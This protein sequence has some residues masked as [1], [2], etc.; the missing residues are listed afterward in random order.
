MDGRKPEYISGLSFFALLCASFVILCDFFHL[1]FNRRV[2]TFADNVVGIF[3]PVCQTTASLT[4]TCATFFFFFLSLFFTKSRKINL[5]RIWFSVCQNFHLASYLSMQ[6][7]PVVTL[8]PKAHAGP[9][10]EGQQ[11][12]VGV[13]LGLGGDLA[14]G[15][16]LQQSL[17]P[18]DVFGGRRPAVALAVNAR[19]A[20]ACAAPAPR[21]QVGGTWE[22]A[23]GEEEHGAGGAVT[24]LWGG[25]ER[26]GQ[27]LTL[28]VEEEKKN[29]CLLQSQPNLLLFFIFIC[30]LYG[31][32][33]FLC[34]KILHTTP[35]N[36]ENKIGIFWV[37]FLKM[38]N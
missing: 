19:N 2:W 30:I 11:G 26:R 14:E 20:A 24:R 34:I 13:R 1:D 27:G 8:P 3:Q 12:L 35:P 23:P 31:E 10:E 6:R 37:V 22:D 28:D 17:Q 16:G 9:H 33:N 7:P 5:D 36:K 25:E 21:E 32:L 29:R 38:K 18:G 15:A 4:T